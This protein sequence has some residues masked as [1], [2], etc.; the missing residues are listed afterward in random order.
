M[1]AVSV[2]KRTACR[3]DGGEHRRV[4]RM[5]GEDRDQPS[6]PIVVNHI[7]IADRTPF[8][9][10]RAR[11][12]IENRPTSAHRDRDDERLEGL[13]N[14]QPFDAEGRRSLA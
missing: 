9:F 4:L 7:S 11:C 10:R 3:V 8:L 14:A 5:L 2:R 12:W 6:M 13:G 1:R